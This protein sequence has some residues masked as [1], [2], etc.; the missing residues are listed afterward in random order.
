MEIK[1]TYKYQLK[2]G[3]KVILRDFTTDLMQAEQTHKL[4]YPNAH[5][6]KIE[7]K[8]TRKAAWLWVNRGGRRRYIKHTANDTPRCKSSGGKA[9]E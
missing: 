8:T 2:I 4:N 6:L 1:D 9:Y 5:I 3:R 7:R